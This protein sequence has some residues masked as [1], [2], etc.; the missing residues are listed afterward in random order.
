[1][2]YRQYS[3]LFQKHKNNQFSVLPF[4]FLVRVDNQFYCTIKKEFAPGQTYMIYNYFR[5]ANHRFFFLFVQLPPTTNNFHTN[6][7]PVIKRGTKQFLTT[8]SSQNK[9]TIF[10][11]HGFEKK[12]YR[13]WCPLEMHY[14]KMHYP[15]ASAISVDRGMI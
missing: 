4:F 8:F 11:S 12:K 6:F 10:Y 2:F 7:L 13:E 15:R 5:I 1:M 9:V 3:E 14:P